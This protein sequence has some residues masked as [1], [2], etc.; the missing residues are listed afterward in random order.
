MPSGVRRTGTRGLERLGQEVSKVDHYGWDECDH[1]S[2][3]PGA[4]K[5]TVYR[6]EQPAWDAWSRVGITSPTFEPW[7]VQPLEFAYLA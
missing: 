5:R 2:K 6:R 3:G 7:R 1:P 4:S